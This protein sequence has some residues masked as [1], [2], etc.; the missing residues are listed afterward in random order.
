MTDVKEYGKALFE[1]AREAGREDFVLGDVGCVRTVIVGEPSYP[2]LLDSP[3]LS[4][5]E[6]VGIADAAFGALDEYLVNMIKLL[7]EKR[8]AFSIIKALDGY[9]CA[10]DEYKGIERVEAVS[11]V[12]L[13]DSQL[14]R[15][16]SK[17]ESIT[18]KQIIINN[19]VDAS[20]LGGMKLR[21]MGVQLD[22]SVKTRLDNFE[23]SLRDLV[24]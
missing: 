9:R 14:L 19:T 16:K 7:V 18:G 2:A 10:Y 8:M 12:A 13:S 6:R 15:L 5:E 4:K 21:Y 20:I 17:L 11:A 22:G 3:A 1:L 23:K 24:V